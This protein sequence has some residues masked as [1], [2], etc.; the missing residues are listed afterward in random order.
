MDPYK[1]NQLIFGKQTKAYNGEK[2]VFLT[3]DA[4]ITGHS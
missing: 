1:Y 4:G 2:I 3:N